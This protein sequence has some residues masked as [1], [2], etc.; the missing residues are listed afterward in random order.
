MS[1]ASCTGSC[2]APSGRAAGTEYPGCSPFRWLK[3]ER[4]GRKRVLA[5]SAAGVSA[6]TDRLRAKAAQRAASDP[7]AAPPRTAAHSGV[8]GRAAN[9]S[10]AVLSARKASLPRPCSRP[11]KVACKVSVFK[12]SSPSGKIAREYAKNRFEKVCSHY[13][14]GS[15]KEKRRKQRNFDRFFGEISSGKQSVF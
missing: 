9:R 13:S 15:D 8:S 10:A 12:E 2:R 7:A 5:G 11:Q 3:M 6:V 14:T 4:R 1:G